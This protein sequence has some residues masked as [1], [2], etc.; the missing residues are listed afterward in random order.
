LDPSIT[1][2]NPHA[3]TITA[4]KVNPETKKLIVGTAIDVDINIPQTTTTA[5]NTFAIVIANENYQNVER[6]ENAM[7]D[8]KVV[9]QYLISTLG[10]P[11]DQVMLYSDASYGNII[12]AIDKIKNISKAYQGCEFNIIFY[13]AGH[14]VPDE[15][16]HEAYLLQ[17]D[18]IPNNLSVNIPLRKLYSTLGNLGASSVFVM[19]DACFSGSQRGDG[20]LAQARGV[21]IKAKD[22]EPKGNMIIL[23]AAQGDETAYSYQDKSHGMFTY[24]LLKKLQES[25][26]VNFN[27]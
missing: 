20:M 27:W 15:Q 5:K 22:A 25:K 3:K 6:V 14:G 26:G 21:A 9:A 2:S 8:G 1:I 16:S 17:T 4:T 23:S 7:N 24:F 19:L 11:H 18:G 12:S 13:Y 10:V